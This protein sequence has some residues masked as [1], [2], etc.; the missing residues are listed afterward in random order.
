MISCFSLRFSWFG[1]DIDD[2]FSPNGSEQWHYSMNDGDQLLVT[3]GRT[4]SLTSTAVVEPLE[5]SCVY[6]CGACTHTEVI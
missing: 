5:V 4:L 2:H 1:V 3:V 6:E